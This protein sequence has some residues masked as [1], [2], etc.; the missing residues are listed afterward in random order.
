MKRKKH[1]RPGARVRKPGA[2]RPRS[3]DPTPSPQA[4]AKRCALARGGD[5]AKTTNPLDLLEGRGLISPA[6]SDAGRN[7]GWLRRMVFGRTEARVLDPRQ[8]GGRD[9]A[10]E[11]LDWER[12][13]GQYRRLGAALAQRGA[14]VRAA[15]DSVCVYNRFPKALLGTG[16]VVAGEIEALREGLEALDRAR[17][18]PRSWPLAPDPAE[19]AARGR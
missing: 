12:I 6:Q 17:A 15:T 3:Y 9:V 13:E 8:R 14:G 11:A 10:L 18:T 19:T 4:M 2:G 7:Y 5:P 16:E 1:N